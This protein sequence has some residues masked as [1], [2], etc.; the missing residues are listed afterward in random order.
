MAIRNA[1]QISLIVNRAKANMFTKMMYYAEG[2]SIG[3]TPVPYLKR[4]S[5]LIWGC[6]SM[7]SSIAQKNQFADQIGALRY[8]VAPY[9][10]LGILNLFNP[11]L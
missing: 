9:D 5:N 1:Y 6:E 7:Y 10:G 8:D 11:E 3:V 4:Q 2:L